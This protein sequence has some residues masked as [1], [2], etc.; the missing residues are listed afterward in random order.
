MTPWTVAHKAP[1]PRGFSRQEYWSGLPSPSPG[2]FPTQGLNLH[3]LSLLHLQAGSLPLAPPGKSPYKHQYMQII[4]I[5]V[6]EFL[7]PG[8]HCV[9]RLRNGTL[10]SPQK[11]PGYF[12]PKVSTTTTLTPNH[13]AVLS[14]VRL[15]ATPWTAARQAPLSMGFSRQEYWSGVP[16]PPPGDL[17]NPGI[18][19]R[20]PT[21]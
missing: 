14:R 6:Y 17:P 4:S 8:T 10:P 1:Q 12:P 19:P 7:C 18:E 11:A 15:S 16:H 20:S 21:L 13:C 5:Q 2:V 9:S 3:L